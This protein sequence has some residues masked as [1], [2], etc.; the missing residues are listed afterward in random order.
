MYVVSEEKAQINTDSVLEFSLFMCSIA[1]R[2][3]LR[4]CVCEK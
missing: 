3:K 4:V 1:M 2:H